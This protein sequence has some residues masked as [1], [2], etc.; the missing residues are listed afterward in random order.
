MTLGR[1]KEVDGYTSDEQ[2]KPTETAIMPN[3]DFYIADG[4]GENYIIKY[5][6]K[7]KFIRHFGGKGGKRRKIQLLPRHYF[8]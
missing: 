2:F 4:Y 3:G 6:A 8:G 1:P 7:G 5:D